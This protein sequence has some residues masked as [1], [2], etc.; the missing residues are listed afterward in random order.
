MTT[1]IKKGIPDKEDDDRGDDQD[2]DK[3]ANAERLLLVRRCQLILNNIPKK[4]IVI[5]RLVD[6]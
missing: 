1:N 5:S 2:K 3:Y 6:A 4:I